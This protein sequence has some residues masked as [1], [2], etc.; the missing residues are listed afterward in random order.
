MG[1]WFDVFAGVV[2]VGVVCFCVK[3]AWIFIQL[4]LACSI[5]ANA[6]TVKIPVRGWNSRKK[7]RVCRSARWRSA[8]KM[9]GFCAPKMSSPGP[10]QRP[11]MH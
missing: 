3:K 5:G 8:I 2:G 6:G 11:T 10:D 1:K 4:S 7:Q 9:A